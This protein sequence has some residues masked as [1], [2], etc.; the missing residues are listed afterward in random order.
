MVIVFSDSDANKSGGGVG[1]VGVRVGEIR[2]W[3]KYA[4]GRTESCHPSGNCTQRQ[5]LIILDML[6]ISWSCYA[7]CLFWSWFDMIYD[8]LVF[9]L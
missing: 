8:S 2:S 5:L 9:M 6:L 4:L 3:S 1:G 7:D